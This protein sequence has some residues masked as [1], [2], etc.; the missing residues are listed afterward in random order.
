MVLLKDP[1]VLLKGPGPGYPELLPQDLP[2]SGGAAAP[3]GLHP[4]NG[5]EGPPSVPPQS[6]KNGI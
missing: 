6:G 2:G 4:R 3:H 1:G 5:A